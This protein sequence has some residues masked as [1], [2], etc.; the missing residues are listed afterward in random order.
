[1]GD[2]D[3]VDWD[4][5]PSDQKDR[6]SRLDSDSSGEGRRR[7]R[8]VGGYELIEPIGE[9]SKGAFGEVWLAKRRE[10]RLPAELVAI[11]FMRPDRIHPELLMRL[12]KRESIAWLNHRSIVTV[13]AFGRDGDPYLVMEYVAG[14][15]LAK[16]CDKRKLSLEARLGLLEKVCEAVHQVHLFGVLHGDLQPSH[17]MVKEARLAVES[18]PKLLLFGLATSSN[19]RGV[20]GSRPY[21]SPERAGPTS[22]VI[23]T[24]SDIYS[25]GVLLYELI[26]GVTPMQ[27]VLDDASLDPMERD[28][29]LAHDGRPTMA[30]AFARMAPEQRRHVAAARGITE[31]ALERRLRSRLSHL[32]EKALRLQPQNRYQT[33]IAMAED[34]R[35]Y[36]SDRD[37]VEASEAT[38]PRI[39]RRLRRAFGG[40]GAFSD[41]RPERS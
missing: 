20:T 38:L 37:F 6:D 40:S 19:A 5:R 21:A 35:A 36:L 29:R 23:D 8:V 33:A 11:K 31:A 26:A 32:V 24:R 18:I 15:P 25:L 12:E 27:H 7:G 17:I 34:I 30:W 41:D 2:A 1:M 13:H 39:L 16:H 14:D 3:S 4:D 22:E 9:E 10:P 28:H